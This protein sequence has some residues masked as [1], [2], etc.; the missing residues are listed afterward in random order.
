MFPDGMD[1]DMSEAGKPSCLVIA[2]STHPQEYWR[3][4]GRVQQVRPDQAVRRLATGR[5]KI[6]QDAMQPP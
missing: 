6:S 4:D 3:L 2:L 1:V 5:S